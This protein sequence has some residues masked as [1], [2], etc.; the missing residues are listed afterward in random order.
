MDTRA[1]AELRPCKGKE[2]DGCHRFGIF[3][4]NGKPAGQGLGLRGISC[5]RNGVWKGKIMISMEKLA[6][7]T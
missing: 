6:E 3:L 7:T 2:F 5:L 1:G 4:G